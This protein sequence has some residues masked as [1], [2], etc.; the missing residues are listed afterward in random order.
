MAIEGFTGSYRFLSNFYQSRLWYAGHIYPTAEHAFQAAKATTAAQEKVIREAITPGM[1]KRMGR[2]AL[3]RV[4][5]DRMKNGIMHDIL[6]SKFTENPEL[7]RKLL[8]TWPHDLIE[9]NEWGD[10]YWGVYNGVGDNW[11]GILLKDARE[12]FRIGQWT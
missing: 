11:L 8:N 10:P 9:V 5:W 6:K 7:R 3:I 4:G 12:K 2:R 1:A